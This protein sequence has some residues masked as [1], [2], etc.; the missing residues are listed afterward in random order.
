MCFLLCLGK[1]ISG[2]PAEKCG[3]LKIG[4]RILAVNNINITNLTHGDV[5]NLIKDSGLQVKL[6]IGN[7]KDSFLY[8]PQPTKVV[9]HL[10]HF[11]VIC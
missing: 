4:D 10:N 3:E 8:D 1:L 9:D 11:P 2:S 7:P 5:V 6:T